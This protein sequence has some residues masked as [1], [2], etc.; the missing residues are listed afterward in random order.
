MG[1]KTISTDTSENTC[2]LALTVTICAS[3]VFV[4]S[5]MNTPSLR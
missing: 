3:S 2:S 4:R 5:S 1:V